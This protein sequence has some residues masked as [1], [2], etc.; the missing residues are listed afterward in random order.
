MSFATSSALRNAS[1]TE[2]DAVRTKALQT[3]FNL[4]RQIHVSDVF[5][6]WEG[7][8]Q[9]VLTE[10]VMR[11][12]VAF[13]VQCCL[14]STNDAYRRSREMAQITR[15]GVLTI[16]KAHC[17]RERIAKSGYIRCAKPDHVICA[18]GCVSSV[19]STSPNNRDLRGCIMGKGAISKIRDSVSNCISLIHF[20]VPI[21]IV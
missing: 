11:T 3:R 7:L 16:E 9:S 14:V 4:L 21:L 19:W 2:G 20:P 6:F 15:P 17:L 1:P 13:E 12:T 10:S 5:F 18:R 8:Q